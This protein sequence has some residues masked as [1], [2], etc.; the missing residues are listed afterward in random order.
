M[1]SKIKARD[2]TGVKAPKYSRPKAQTGQ[3]EQATRPQQDKSLNTKNVD[4]RTM[5]AEERHLQRWSWFLGEASRQAANRTMMARCEAF[6]DG[7]QWDYQDAQR[8]KDRGQNPVVYNVIKPTI[9]WLI[10]TERRTRVDFYV[11]SEGDD[12]PNTTDEELDEDATNKTKLLKFLDDTNRAPFERSFAAEDAFKAGMGWLEVGV[13]MDREGPPVYVGAESWRNVLWDSHAQKRDLSDARYFF[14]TKVVDLDVAIALFPGKRAEIERCRQTGDNA[15]VFGDALGGAGLIAG[16]DQFTGIDDQFDDVSS[17][18]V[19]MFNPRE[20]I[21]LLECWSREPFP[22]KT[23]E[24]GTPGPVTFKMRVSVMTEHDTLIESW[25]PYNHNRAPFIPVWGYR[26]RRTGLPYSPVKAVMGPQEALNH[27]MCKSL[28]EA[29]ANQI[30][31][32]VGAIDSESMDINEIRDELNSPDGIAVYANGALSGN[33]VRS[34]DNPGAAARQLDLAERDIMHIRGTSGVSSENING[35]SNLVSG[36]ALLAKADQGSLLTGELFDNQLLARQMEGEMTLSLCEQYITGPIMVRLAGDGD[37]VERTRLNQPQADGTYLN[38]ITA[39]RAKF[40]VGE[41]AWKQNYAEAAFESLMQVMT[42]LASAAPQV[43]VALLDVVFEMH[44]N[45]P[46][47]TAV[48]NRIRSVNGQTADDGKMTPEQ[49]KAKQQ[50]QQVAEAQFAAQMAQMM[51]DVKMAQAQGVKLEAEAMKTR[52]TA[53]YEA[54]Q[55]AQV[56]AQMPGATPIADELLKSAGFVDAAGAGAL[57]PEMMQQP[58]QPMQQPAQPL[59]EL[60][61]GDG[62]TAGIET[63]APDGV[64]QPE[65]V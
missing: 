21:M 30:E 35:Q 44:P 63:P 48:L 61:Q 15:R 43:V 25:S 31:I 18:P 3:A 62:A 12:D 46:R 51:A 60:Q 19:D 55:A 40:S 2:A 26:N 37:K 38:D 23:N 50:Q 41:Q 52:L 22:G 17:R 34:R 5:T 59:P 33:R 13:R 9:D 14:R 4:G 54:A 1:A 36:K 24:D 45:L 65:G 58:A 57:P 32:E 56:L 47:K 8:V 20:R 10:G 11:V 16:L 7:E 42:Q 64:I 53:L 39:R 49:A 28:Y 6:Y 27:R 29:S